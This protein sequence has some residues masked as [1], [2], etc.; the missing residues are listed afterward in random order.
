MPSGEWAG[1][2]LLQVEE[3]GPVAVE[4]QAP[5]D[6]PR[7]RR[8]PEAVQCHRR[9]GR[10]ARVALLGQGR[11]LGHIRRGLRHRKGRQE[12]GE[13]DEALKTSAQQVAMHRGYLQQ[14]AQL[15]PPVPG[16]QYRSF[17]TVKSILW[18]LLLE[19][20]VDPSKQ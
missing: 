15:T 5:R 11:G 20:A 10:Q 8:L 16:F 9:A 2:L 19:N 7:G 12:Q 4:G 1:E 17:E 6:V 14:T 18:L 13:P 3:V